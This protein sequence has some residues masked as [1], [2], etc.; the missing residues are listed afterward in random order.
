MTLPR[1]LPVFAVTFAGAAALFYLAAVEYNLA[2][3]TYHP[4]TK[5]FEFLAAPQRSGPAMYWYGWI[6]TA[7]LGGAAAGLL[8]TFIPGPWAKRL[9]TGLAWVVP[10]F[11]ILAFLYL[12]RVYFLR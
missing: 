10:A 6:A 7:G 9:W 4:L 5:Q 3:F 11:V 2:L 12:L 1:A 8:A